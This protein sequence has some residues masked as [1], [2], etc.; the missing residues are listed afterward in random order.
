MIHTPKTPEDLS[1]LMPIT[2]E[3]QQT[4]SQFA[5]EQ[6]TPPKALQVYL[7]TLAVY[8]VSHYLRMLGIA[9]NLTAGDSWN[10]VLRFASDVADL[11]VTNVGRLECRPLQDHQ[12]LVPPETQD[13]RIGYVAV[14]I[15]LEQQTAR[16]LG[17]TP[18]VTTDELALRELQP[19]KQLLQHLEN[20]QPD[21]ALV[22]LSQWWHNIFEVGWQSVEALLDTQFFPPAAGQVAFR[23]NVHPSLRRA[24]VIH[25]QDSES[26][27]S[28]IL[29]VNLVQQITGNFDIHLQVFPL[30]S[31]TE[32]PQGLTLNILDE[33]GNLFF[34]ITSDRNRAVLQSRSFSGQPEEQFQVQ[35][36][37]GKNSIT[38]AFVI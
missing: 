24:K 22:K 14:Q 17:F 12:C 9:T 30:E 32:L 2:Q 10:P 18:V 29:V 35:I 26:R 15:D 1:V 21:T 5:S 16:L 3:A 13:D 37:L 20:G 33:A 36:S 4:A 31:E 28:V 25:L 34:E 38:E 23:K 27:V 19:I 6:P 8:A 11:W 7:N